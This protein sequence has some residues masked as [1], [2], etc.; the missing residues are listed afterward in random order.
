MRL[1]R[2]P[3]RRAGN[4]LLLC[5][6]MIFVIF[7]MAALVIDL[8]LARV[9]HR[10]MQ[11]ATD[12]SAR[13]G[14]RY[15]DELPPWLMDPNSAS[16]FVQQMHSELGIGDPTDPNYRDQ[17]RRWMARAQ[18]NLVFTDG[19]DAETGNAVQ[20]G[21]GPQY[22]IDAGQ[23]DGNALQFIHVPDPRTDVIV[24]KPALQL[25]FNGNKLINDPSGDLVAGAFILNPNYPADILGN[26]A[27][28]DNKYIRRDFIEDGPAVSPGTAFL[29]RLRRTKNPQG[30][31][32]NTYDNQPNISTTGNALPLTFG[33]AIM[34]PQ[35]PADPTPRRNGIVV[36]GTSIAQGRPVLAAGLA[37]I[38]D[39]TTGEPGMSGVGTFSI[40]LSAWQGAPTFTIADVSFYSA[41]RASGMVIVGDTLAAAPTPPT[42]LPPSTANQAYVPLIDA[43]TGLVAGFGNVT[44]DGTTLTKVVPRIASENATASTAVYVPNTSDPSIPDPKNANVLSVLS[45]LLSSTNLADNQTK[46]LFATALIR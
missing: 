14:I 44:T 29:V 30:I 34:L 11:A 23:G 12:S 10:Q 16:P 31:D 24:Y 6:L 21:A 13:E 2:Q 28:K 32:Q 19:I 39:A 25:N 22:A 46:F 45:P 27:V 18:V 8:G 40:T 38:A 15:R 42:S 1:A 17:V 35:N 9:T 41:P 4:V 33:Q 20:F 43:A 36:R 37:K 26:E 5:A 3:Q 7:A